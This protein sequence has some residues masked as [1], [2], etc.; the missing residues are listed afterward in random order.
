MKS[1]TPKKRENCLILTIIWLAFTIF[2]IQDSSQLLVGA[3]FLKIFQKLA[4]SLIQKAGEKYQ[5]LIGIAKNKK[6]DNCVINLNEKC[7]V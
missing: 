6:P 2:S 7:H 5:K 4:Q 3:N 1:K